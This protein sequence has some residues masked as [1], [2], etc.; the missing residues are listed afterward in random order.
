MCQVQ[1]FID[2]FDYSKLSK[3]KKDLSFTKCILVFYLYLNL[4]VEYDFYG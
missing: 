1:Y 4:F 3:K 2:Y